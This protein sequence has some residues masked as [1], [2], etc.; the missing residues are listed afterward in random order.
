MKLAEAGGPLMGFVAMGVFWGAWGTLIP[1]VKTTTA[2]SDAEL[3]M[4]LLCVALGAIPAMI[5]GG[6]MVDRL[7]VRLLLPIAIAAFGASAVLPAMAQDPF[8]LGLCL[9]ILGFCSGFMDIIM[10]C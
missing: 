1:V 5:L 3:G 6:R 2:A 10:K 9:L 4:A 7:G 8:A